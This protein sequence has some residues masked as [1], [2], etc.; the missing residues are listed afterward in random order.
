[1][2]RAAGMGS[3][4]PFIFFYRRGRGIFFIGGGGGVLVAWLIGGTISFA[5]RVSLVAGRDT[6]RG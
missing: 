4:V 6:R 3:T 1:M 5:E 2:T